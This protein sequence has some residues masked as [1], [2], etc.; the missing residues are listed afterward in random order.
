MI[1][2]TARMKKPTCSITASVLVGTLSER[3]NPL[4]TTEDSQDAPRA[5]IER[6]YKLTQIDWPALTD[7]SARRVHHPSC[8]VAHPVPKQ[9]IKQDAQ[10]PI[11]HH[12]CGF[13]DLIVGC[14]P[15]PRHAVVVAYLP[16]CGRR[17][18]GGGGPMRRG[19]SL[20]SAAQPL[21][22]GTFSVKQQGRKPSEASL[23]A[24]SRW[25]S[26]ALR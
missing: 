15:R 11:G 8:A 24:S 1:S 17:R 9:R 2:A 12:L 14:I 22:G 6:H 23:L 5:L 7:R 20:A 4:S 25:K 13:G 19:L 18:D 26:P 21:C 16:A 10:V 3:Q